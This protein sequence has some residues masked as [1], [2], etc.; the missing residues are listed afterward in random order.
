MLLKKT[1]AHP[2]EL[3]FTPESPHIMR[4]YNTIMRAD[5][6]YFE[7]RRTQWK[8]SIGGPKGAKSEN[9]DLQIFR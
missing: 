7:V 5:N 1:V 2:G 6:I 3:R 8:F 9:W 4:A